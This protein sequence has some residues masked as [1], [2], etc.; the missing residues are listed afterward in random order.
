M[1]AKQTVVFSDLSPH[2]CDIFSRT[3]V[4]YFY[5]INSS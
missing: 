4:W 1:R 3:K 5:C 2:A